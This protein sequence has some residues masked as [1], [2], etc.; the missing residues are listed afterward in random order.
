MENEELLR[1]GR[2][3]YCKTTGWIG[4]IV[5]DASMFGMWI[6][7]FANGERGSHKSNELEPLFTLSQVVDI[8]IEEET[9]PAL[10]NAVIP[11]GMSSEELAEESAQ[12]IAACVTRIRGVGNEQYDMQGHQKFEELD[13]DELLDYTLEEIQDIANYAVFLGIRVKRIQHALRERDDLGVGTEEEFEQTDYSVQD[14]E[15]NG[16]G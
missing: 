15:E 8:K 9:T 5:D 7:D 10:V 16:N 1:V 6:V 12:F 3:V 14:F 11:F 13:L 2:P 4:E